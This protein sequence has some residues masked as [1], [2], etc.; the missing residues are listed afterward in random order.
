[1][2]GINRYINEKLVIGKNIIHNKKYFVPQSMEELNEYAKNKI[3]E[4]NY[5][6][7]QKNPI[8]LSYID[9]TEIGNL[10][11]NN[12]NLD[13]FLQDVV[14]GN[15]YEKIQYLNMKNCK[16]GK[17][18]SISYFFSDL[19]NL[20]EVNISN[21]DLGQ[22]QF[23]KGL[24]SDNKKLT[25][26]Y[27][28][29]NLNIGNISGIA[30]MF[31]NCISLTELDLSNWN[32]ENITTFGAMFSGCENLKTI[33]DISSWN[34]N[35]VRWMKYMFRGCENLNNIPG[36]ENLKFPNCE[37]CSRMFMDC[38]NMNFE[39]N[40]SNWNLPSDVEWDDMF[41]NSNIKWYRKV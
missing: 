4:G 37:N 6:G 38:A 3:I 24:F 11:N 26:I 31:K 5:T 23:I 12:N 13:Y 25:K 8:D 36:I 2:K 33:G 22:V 14:D 34:T 18:K 10:P 29:E 7:T 15:S 39:L 1:M 27:G 35:K 9:F 20:Q 17:M 28:I 21:W 30:T 19:I 16:F 41:L 32:T 40:L